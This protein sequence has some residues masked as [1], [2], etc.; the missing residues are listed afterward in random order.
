M[1]KWILSLLILAAITGCSDKYESLKEID[2][3]PTLGLSA[4]TLYVRLNDTTTS[5]GRLEIFTEDP[6]NDLLQI[7]YSDTSN[8]KISVIYDQRPV[9]D[10]LLPVIGDSTRVW[11]VANDSGTYSVAFTLVDRFGK[12]D[13]RP[14]I[15]QTLSSTLPT[16]RFGITPDS[17][18]IYTIDGSGS[19][20]PYGFI[21]Q[22]HYSVDG[23]DIYSPGP[24]IHQTF[25]E[26]G[27][28]TVSLTV[29]DDVHA[30]SQPFSQ[31]LNIP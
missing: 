23:Q 17:E 18:A 8:G 12:T 16:A 11:L 20:D 19:T 21:V 25:Y 26:P 22:Y 1:K 3:A 14:V 27:T 15:V 4:D 9:A 6:D 30:Y 10:G 7:R 13:S 24:V 31:T 2:R 5:A 28:H 29:E